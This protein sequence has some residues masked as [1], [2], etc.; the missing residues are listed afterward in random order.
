M[1]CP[2]HD[3]FSQ[4]CDLCLVPTGLPKFHFCLAADSSNV[5]HWAVC[6]CAHS[7]PPITVGPGLVQV[8]HSSLA[9][10]AAPL[11]SQNLCIGPA[12]TFL[13][14]SREDIVEDEVV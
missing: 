13:C 7:W 1:D 14:H 8:P 4:W 11:G 10:H 12:I 3:S 6:F 9:V 5:Q 2:F